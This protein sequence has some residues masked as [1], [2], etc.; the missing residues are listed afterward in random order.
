MNIKSIIGLGA[1]FILSSLEAAPGELGLV[2]SWTYVNENDAQAIITV[3]RSNGSD[4]SVSVNFAAVEEESA[5][6]TA[7]FT[8]VSG[9]LT[10][11]PGQISKSFTIPITNDQIPEWYENFSIFLS[12][13]TGGATLGRSDGFVGITDDDATDP[14]T[15]H[16]SSQNISQSEGSGQVAVVIKRT[17]APAETSSVQYETSNGS[18]LAGI[19]YVPSAGTVSFGYKETSK[20]IFI[21]LINDAQGEPNKSFNVILKN[22]SAGRLLGAPSQMVITIENDD[23]ATEVPIDNPEDPID[24]PQPPIDNPQTPRDDPNSPNDNKDLAEIKIIQPKFQNL[25]DWTKKK[26]LTIPYSVNQGDN[27][28]HHIRMEIY[29]LAGEKVTTLIDKAATGSGETTWDAK[30]S[31]NSDI[32]PDV[33]ILTSEID[34]K[35]QPSRKIILVK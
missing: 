20:T 29:T 14:E 19:D 18:A 22:P 10:F 13:P 24:N 31:N 5:L 15:F 26:T 30:N 32:A 21:S 17:E 8:R 3:I 4:G 33:Y 25:F 6:E 7:D 28:T 35:P 9:T 23:D 16:F 12:L 1:F 34:G 27:S 11:S 2:E